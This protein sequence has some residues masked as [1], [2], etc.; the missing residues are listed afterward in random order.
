MD[1]YL[2]SGPE[3]DF[4]VISA[5]G[6]SENITLGFHPAGKLLFSSV[7]RE[8]TSWKHSGGKEGSFLTLD[9]GDE[10]SMYTVSGFYQFKCLAYEGRIVDLHTDP[11]SDLG[12]TVFKLD[13]CL[14]LLTGGR[15]YR[16]LS[17][18]YSNFSDQSTQKQK[19]EDLLSD[20]I[21]PMLPR[22][23]CRTAACMRT[24]FIR[25]VH[26]VSGVC[27]LCG[28]EGRHSVI[29][30]QRRSCIELSAQDGKQIATSGSVV[31]SKK[32]TTRHSRMGSFC[33]SG[34]YW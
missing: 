13:G 25:S 27:G 20:M 23:L 10:I 19:R 6:D 26:A 24:R 28:V 1:V 15:L 14:L 22:S 30:V 18:N 3:Q 5:E 16:K 29:R 2:D 11:K 32:H 21:L 4:I 31:R 12:K 7:N 8:I 34:S 17:E 9:L 33:P